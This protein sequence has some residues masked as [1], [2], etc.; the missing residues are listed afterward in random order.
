MPDLIISPKP[1]QRAGVESL[2]TRQAGIRKQCDHGRRRKRL[3]A[4]PSK[5]CRYKYDD[6]VTKPRWG[7]GMASYLWQSRHHLGVIISQVAGILRTVLFGVSLLFRLHRRY[8][9]LLGTV[10]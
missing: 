9:S 2:E 10:N 3:A 7:L 6:H 4:C 1:P 5:A 8:A